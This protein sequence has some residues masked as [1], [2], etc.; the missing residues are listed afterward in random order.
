MA[1][2]GG[3]TKIHVHTNEPYDTIKFLMQFA[4]IREG[5][6]EDMQYEADAYTA[7]KNPRADQSPATRAPVVSC[8][9]NN[10]DRAYVVV[11]AWSWV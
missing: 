1:S 10:V 6:I 2:A 4:P 11:F 5:R 8:S 3:L 9:D 7:A